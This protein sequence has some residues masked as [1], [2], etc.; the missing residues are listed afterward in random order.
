MVCFQARGIDGYIGGRINHLLGLSLLDGLLQ[1]LFKYRLGAKP[2]FGITKASNS[3]VLALDPTSSA[4]QTIS[5]GL[6]SN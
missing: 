1:E 2:L 5:R 6:S 3:W 4:T